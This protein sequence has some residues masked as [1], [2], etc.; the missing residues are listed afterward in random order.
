MVP[1]LADIERG[2]AVISHFY[3]RCYTSGY[4]RPRACKVRGAP[5]FNMRQRDIFWFWLP[6]F[7][8]WILMT[9]EGPIISAAINRLP[10]EVVM[11][12]AQ[13]ITLSLAVTIE[14]PI[15][16][17]LSTSTAL[18]KDRA[19]YLLV[20]RFTLHWCIVLTILSLLMAF[21]RL[22]DI[23]VV[24]WLDAPEEVARWVRPGLQI[25][26]PWTAAIAWR[27][28]LQGVLIRFNR[29]QQVAWGTGVRLLSSGG[30]II[31]LALWSELPGVISAATS[32]IV[33]VVAEAIYTTLAVRPL[34]RNE[35]SSTSP[36]TDGAVLTYGELFWFHLPLAS[37]SVLVLLAQPLVTSSLTR[38]DN[39]TQSLAA[40]PVLFQV[41]LM[42]RAPAFAL[43]EAVIALSKGKET[44]APLR[45]FSFALAG[46]L[47]L[48]TAIFL[49][50]PLSHYY[51]FNVQD[52]TRSVGESAASGLRL[53][54]FF[55]ALATFTFW[56]RGLLIGAR[57]TK[58]VNLGMMVNVT[59]TAVI[60]GIG[61]FQ[62]FPGLP[63]A[64][65]ALN[66]ASLSEML[67]L[68]WR[69]RDT[70]FPTLKTYRL[71]RDTG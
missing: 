20:R 46:M 33:G 27:K 56:M 58:E 59:V 29:T 6:L 42:A 53:F 12:A 70:L 35:L 48:G 54:L 32:L 23:V 18:V 71:A 69:S 25:L 64:A 36:P 8:S 1:I 17:L 37:T 3:V 40:W 45:Q 38:L 51:L 9:A 49:F 19:S 31:G 52:M 2:A 26:T 5:G 50:T 24:G 16:S 44:F 10:N 43:P 41:M 39:P 34:L 63:T 57:A 55:P 13:G 11:L 7:A 61:L 14:S 47:T 30:T 15:I 21:T 68:G 62:G 60:L 65:V 28:F 4:G 67:F 66:L 22:F